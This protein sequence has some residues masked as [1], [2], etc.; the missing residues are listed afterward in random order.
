[1]RV[2]YPNKKEFADLMDQ[3]KRIIYKVAMLYTH[4]QED[5][6]DL[7]QDICYQLW[8]S[9]STYRQEASFTTWMYRAAINTAI[10][11][12]RKKKEV[13]IPVESFQEHVDESDSFEKDEQ[14]QFLFKAISL[15]NKIDKAIILLWLE[16]KSYEE[17]ADIL[18]ISK[19]N[20]SVKLVRI[21]KHLAQTMKASEK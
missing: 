6:K 12:M 19:S 17:I 21:K 11:Q 5:K 16:E 7:Y 2:K 13:I 1:M 14:I 3:N 15:L 8:R 9:R 18:G 10:S 4:N 20:V